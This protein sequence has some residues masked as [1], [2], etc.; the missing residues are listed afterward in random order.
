MRS[1]VNKDG[2]IAFPAGMH[3]LV[4]SSAK[5]RF[6]NYVLTFFST[7]T[8]TVMCQQRSRPTREGFRGVSNL[9]MLS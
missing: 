2:T 8:Q 3:I 7:P 6:V 9:I 5:L 4:L 1:A